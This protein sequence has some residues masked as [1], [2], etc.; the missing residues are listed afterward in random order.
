MLLCPIS[1]LRL[2][3]SFGIRPFLI[4]S[5]TN[6]RIFRVLPSPSHRVTILPQ[7]CHDPASVVSRTCLSCVTILPHT[8][9]KIFIMLCTCTLLLIY[10]NNCKII[11]FLYRKFLEDIENVSTFAHVNKRVIPQQN[12]E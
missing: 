5:V 8:C 6:Q 4:L 11:A 9:H 12:K 3:S 1:K 7:L 2:D 10:I